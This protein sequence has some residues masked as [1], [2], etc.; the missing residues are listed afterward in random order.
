MQVYRLENQE[1]HGAYKGDRYK[2]AT[3]CAASVST[4]HC[5]TPTLDG[6]ISF[7]YNHVCGFE[8][9]KKLEDWFPKWRDLL[10]LTDLRV[11]RFTIDGRRTYWAT[12][13]H[14][15]PGNH[16][17]PVVLKGEKQLMFVRRAVELVEE[18]DPETMTWHEVSM[19]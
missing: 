19:R 16:K 18:L 7:S 2:H 11:R 4:P 6:I 14:D 10:E 9:F 5:P 15:F 3:E 1:G 13:D 17:M 8:S 12:G